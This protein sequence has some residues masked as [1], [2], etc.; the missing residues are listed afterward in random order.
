MSKPQTGVAQSPGEYGLSVVYRIKDVPMSAMSV[1]HAGAMLPGLVK[2]FGRTDLP[3]GTNY[4]VGFGPL[5]GSFIWQGNQP[6]GFSRLNSLKDEEI[7]QPGTD[8]DL[9][10][11]LSSNSED[12]NRKLEECLHGYLLNL[13]VREERVEG[14]MVDTIDPSES[15][16][17]VLFNASDP[18][19]NQSCYA[20]VRRIEKVSAKEEPFSN[21]PGVRSHRMNYE[22]EGEKYFL[23]FSFAAVPELFKKVCPDQEAG[24][25]RNFQSSKG[26]FFLPSM[27]VLVSTRMGT[28]R[29]GNLSPTAKW[30]E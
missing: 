13:A 29:M 28:L 30:K 21:I 17:G 4:M 20:W 22:M 18:E 15:M 1:A 19:F 23:E 10:V 11:F 9:W 5:L 2:E 3:S 14:K 8:G 6:R 24:A 16:D 27:D 26:F 12:I 25:V 7:F